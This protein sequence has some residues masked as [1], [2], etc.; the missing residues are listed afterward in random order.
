MVAVVPIFGELA[1]NAVLSHRTLGFSDIV[2]GTNENQVI[3]I[4]E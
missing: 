1:F 2:M 3:G 4:V